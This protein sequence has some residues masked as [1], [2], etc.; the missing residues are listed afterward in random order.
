MFDNL[1]KKSIKRILALSIIFM[2]V[3]FL[4]VVF[5]I[6]DLL[7]MM[8]GHKKFEE[9][10][11]S[12]IK[13]GILVDT[14]T[15]VNFGA[16]LEEYEENTTT[17]ATR[18]T[19]MYYVIWTGDDDD[20]DYRYMAIKVP[21]LDVE[22]MEV[23]AEAVFYGEATQPIEF[24]GVIK[25]M[26]KEEWKYFKEYFLEWGM[27]EA[28][29]DDF[30]I[31]YYIETGA[32]VGSN[33]AFVYVLLVFGLGLIVLGIICLVRSANGGSL[34]SMKKELEACGITEYSAETEYE[35]ARIHGDIRISSRLIFY[36]NGSTP[37]IMPVNKLVWAYQNTTTHRTNGIKT[38]TTYSVVFNTME[39][40]SINVSVKNENMAISVLQDIQQNLPWVIVGYSDDLRGMYNKE[41]ENFLSLRYDKVKNGQLF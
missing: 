6:P 4:F 27:T 37:H 40:K 10:Q 14:Y 31:P 25:E 29:M 18:T 15:E 38:G 9:L 26:D 39:K 1:R 2:V 20:I 3:G 17:H 24:S 41:F 7:T 30:L 12:E 32:L 21:A 22:R 33:A 13:E 36:M 16:F 35:A 28:E 5:Q 19:D 8:K 23:M 11:V 34:K